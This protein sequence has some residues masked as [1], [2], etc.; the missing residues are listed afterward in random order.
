ML[1]IFLH[2]TAINNLDTMS[3][4]KKFKGKI[5]TEKEDSLEDF[6]ECNETTSSKKRHHTGPIR[7]QYIEETGKTVIQIKEKNNFEEKGN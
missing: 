4:N 1:G 7:N 5:W 2:Q 3:L 6:V